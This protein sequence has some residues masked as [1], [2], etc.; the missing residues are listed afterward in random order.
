MQPVSFSKITPF[1]LLFIPIIAMSLVIVTS[2]ELVNHPINDWLTWGAFSYPLSFLVTDITNR[3]FNARAARKV[4]Y[5]GF[6]IGVAL[7]LLVNVRVAIAS[8]SAFLIAQLLDVYLFNKLRDLTWW[9]APLASSIMGSAIDTALFFTIAFI[10]T[11]LP[12]VTWALGDF[13]AKLF[14]A[15]SLLPI[16]KVLVNYYPASLREVKT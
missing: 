7:S 2:N 10:Y 12:W 3:L 5:V 9:K 16:F 11:G 6:A 14:M 8:G 4:V 15:A 13:G 1:W